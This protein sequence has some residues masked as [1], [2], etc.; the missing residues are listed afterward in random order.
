MA[1]DQRVIIKFLSNKR[2]GSCKIAAKLQRQCA[3][4]AYQFQIVQFCMTEIRRGR[5]DLHNE[6]RS[7]GP[8]LDDLDG[9]FFA[10]FEKSPL[11]SA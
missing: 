7:G 1:Y 4:R 10:I 9:K 5:Q 8:L 6:I 11:E 2:A 3:E